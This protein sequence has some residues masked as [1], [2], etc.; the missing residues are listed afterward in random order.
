MLFFARPLCYVKQNVHLFAKDF[1]PLLLKLYLLE[2]LNDI[3]HYS[4]LVLIIITILLYYY[5]H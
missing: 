5:Y 2:L 1:H 3:Y 4:L